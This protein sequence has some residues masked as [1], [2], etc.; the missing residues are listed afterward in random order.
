MGYKSKRV[1][2]PVKPVWEQVP[3]T[4]TLGEEKVEICAQ[5]LKLPLVVFEA[6]LAMDMGMA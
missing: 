2:D 1:R 6:P 3:H 5:S 4:G